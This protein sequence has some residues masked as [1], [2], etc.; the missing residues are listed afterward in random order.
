MV[1]TI[2]ASAAALGI[3]AI[4]PTSISL[5]LLEQFHPVLR[6]LLSVG[7]LELCLSFPLQTF[8]SKHP[9]DILWLP[10][11]VRFFGKNNQST[12]HG[13]LFAASI[14][15]AVRS[16]MM[17]LHENEDAMELF[18]GSTPISLNPDPLR[19]IRW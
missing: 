9:L 14:D 15:L 18:G 6:L 10:R 3:I 7:L 2:L 13:W 8:V 4:P 1:S 16:C 12:G 11:V 19:S 5:S 17:N